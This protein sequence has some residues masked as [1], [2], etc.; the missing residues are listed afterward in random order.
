MLIIKYKA[1]VPLTN[2]MNTMFVGGL[3]IGTDANNQFSMI[4]DTGSAIICVA[5]E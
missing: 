5:S 2:A 1:H 4:F 3:G